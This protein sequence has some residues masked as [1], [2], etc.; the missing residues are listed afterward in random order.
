MPEGRALQAQFRLDP[1]HRGLAPAGARIALPL[2]LR[3]RA[4]PFAIGSYS[5]SKSS[6]AIDEDRLYVGMD[7]GTLYALARD[8]GAVLWHFA[9]QRAAVEA[10]ADGPLHYGIHSSPAFD[11]ERVYVGDYEG[12]LY[13]LDRDQGRLRWERDL[14]GSIGASPV[15]HDGVLHIAVEFPAPDAKVFG[16]DARDGTVRYESNWLGALAH[17]SVSLSLDT[18][19][20]YVGDNAGVLH[21]LD[22]HGGAERWRT[23]VGGAIK[24]T[25]AVADGAVFITSWDHQLH[26]FEALGGR[27]RFTFATGGT[28]MSSPSSDGRRLWFGSDDETLY[29]LDT[30][31][32]EEQWRLSTRG[33]IQSSPTVVTDANLVLV[34]SRDERLYVVD[35]TTGENLQAL[36]LD[37]DITSVP[38]VVDGEVYVSDDAGNVYRFDST[39]PNTDAGL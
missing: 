18:E 22:M 38:V 37:A 26:A 20:A 30:R 1:A 27:E 9:T 16:V 2:M 4:G 31:R 13:A 11:A 34:G 32:G 8:D 10:Q 24:S 19:L 7:D 17:S 28:S 3:W 15:L 25:A 5:A 39:E 21:A 33:A 23:Q 12:V 29:A 35:A 6:P 14:G 36:A